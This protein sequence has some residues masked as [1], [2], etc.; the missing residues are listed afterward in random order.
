MF[1]DGEP[2]FDPECGKYE[3]ACSSAKRTCSHKPL[4]FFPFSVIIKTAGA[5]SPYGPDREGEQL[6]TP[7]VPKAEVACLVDR[8]KFSGVWINE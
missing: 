6:R 3:K 4:I 7:A 5:V 2:G 1:F 8:R